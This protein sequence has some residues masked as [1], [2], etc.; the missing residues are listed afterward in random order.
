MTTTTRT[1]R[2]FDTAT[3]G[4]TLGAVAVEW[5]ALARAVRAAEEADDRTAA[6]DAIDDARDGL[7][8]IRRSTLRTERPAVRALHALAMGLLSDT[9]ADAAAWRRDAG[10]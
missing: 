6:L 10:F 8:L 9:E 3:L 7:P 1:F 5:P 2:A 4:A